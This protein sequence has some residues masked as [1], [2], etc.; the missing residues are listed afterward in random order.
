[1]SQTNLHGVTGSVTIPGHASAYVS[2]V[3]VNTGQE[4]IDASA[5]GGNGWR[6]RIGGLKDLAGTAVGFASK[7]AAGTNPFAEGEG[8]M[9]ITY[10][11]GCTITISKAIIGNVQVVMEYANITVFTFEWSNATDAAPTI[12]WDES[13]SS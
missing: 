9:V 3:S 4:L 10:D 8:E 6:K 1:M 11:T 12:S 5:F 13:S 2:S 7:G